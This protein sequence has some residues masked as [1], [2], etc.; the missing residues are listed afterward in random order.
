MIIP[1]GQERNSVR[2]LPWVTILIIL[3]SFII[4]LNVKEKNKEIY[5]KVIRVAR[6]LITYYMNHPYL[7]ID[8][9]KERN[10]INYEGE[11]AKE[12]FFKLFRERFE[13]DIPDEE[14]V[15]EEQKKLN[16]Y[17]DRINDLKEEHPFV[18]WGFTP[19]KKNLK[20]SITYMFIHGGWIHLLSNLFLL[21][22]VGPYIED[23]WG[24]T[25][26]AASYLIIGVFSAYA[27]A[28]HYPNMAGPLIGASGA[29][30]GIMG[31]FLVRFWNAKI[32][33]FFWFWFIWGKFKAP[34]WLMIPI[35][36]GN[37]IL[38]AKE[39]DSIY[40]NGSGVAHW[41]HVWG[42]VFGVLLAVAL[43]FFKYE[44]KVVN[45]KYEEKFTFTDRGFLDYEKALQLKEEGKLEEAF[46]LLGES[47]KRDIKN[48]DVVELLWVIGTDLNRTEEIKDIFKRHIE[49]ELKSDRVEAAH[50]HYSKLLE[51]YPKILINTQ[52]LL[53][54]LKYLIDSKILAEA[55]DIAKS[56]YLRTKENN[57]PGFLVPFSESLL[58]LKSKYTDD[59]LQRTLNNHE[60]PKYK[61]IEL[62]EKYTGYLKSFKNKEG[63]KKPKKISVIRAIPL[64]VN[65]EAFVIMLENKNK[66]TLPLNRITTISTVK[67]SSYK[68]KIVYLIDLFLDEPDSGKDE[69]RIVR[70]FSMDFDPV[71]FIPKANNTGEA[72]KTFIKAILKFSGA[73][74]LINIDYLVLNKVKL[75]QSIE[76]YNKSL[77]E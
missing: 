31:A 34:A 39:M 58:L 20:T 74:P 19:V 43:S 70:L 41:A 46:N 22:L 9:K 44:Q 63:A 76:E 40:Q 68:S 56:V 1:Y 47:A 67:I 10:E 11:S 2:L 66:T 7:I 64:S 42:F 51:A 55:E 29:I 75:Y 73:K 59:V 69:I 62:K 3:I 8:K 21:Y 77:V 15:A 17:I 16:E 45:K 38:T 54:L 60:V 36:F 52:L 50:F 5:N 61:K 24:K 12:R 30:S 14:T 37:E 72:F 35:W 32:K 13:G 57:L 71:K 26:Y 53:V 33:F 65:R 49:Y 48:T 27:F 6:K 18:K 4:H 23:V 28:A 25:M